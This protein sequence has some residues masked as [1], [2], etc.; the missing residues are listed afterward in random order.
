M[1]QNY[2]RRIG[3]RDIEHW[4]SAGA[5]G[6]HCFHD[7]FLEAANRFGN[8]PA[9]I[10][11]QSSVTFR[12]LARAVLANGRRLAAAAVGPRS[13]VA[14]QVRND[15][16]FL[17]GHLA[18]SSLGAVT[19]TLPAGVTAAEFRE[20]TS[21]GSVDLVIVSPDRRD[22]LAGE[23][24]SGVEV[25][26]F[27]AG[28]LVL[29]LADADT[30]APP[31]W[32]EPDA[33]AVMVPTA[34]TT[35]L[36]KLAIR[37]HNAWLAMGKK[38][39]SSLGGVVPRPGEKVLVLSPLAQGVGY[40]HGFIIPLLIPGV[41]RVIT[42]RFDPVAA[43]D[44]IER[45]RP[46]EIVGVPAQ[47]DMLVEALAHRPRDLSSIRYAQ[48]GGDHM[49]PEK[50]R[51]FEAA[52]G[53]PVLMDYGASD[54][55]A[56]C[57]NRP[58]DPPDVRLTTAGR[59]MPWTDLVILGPEGDPLPVGT[60]GEIALNGPDII[61]GYY[62]DD[63]GRQ[64]QWYRTGD[65][66]HLDEDGNLVVTGRR[67]DLIIRGGLNISPAEIQ[68]VLLRHPSVLS[69]AVVGMTD[70]VLGERIGAFLVVHGDPLQVHASL[71]RY[72]ESSGLNVHKWPERIFYVD[73]LPL[74]PVGK[75]NNSMLRRRAMEENGKSLDQA[76]EGTRVS[77][78][79]RS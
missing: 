79:R 52:F 34:G 50:R 40:I 70:P 2:N 35:S 24:T 5:W 26:S 3:P 75:V 4:R 65:V 66:G 59:A 10:T 58:D 62:P 46:V 27:N 48:T 47:L 15:A 69:A 31:L 53:V 38:K 33:D 57:T 49:A 68:E 9:V 6:D 17:S 20:L 73:E 39:I 13:V 74:T 30:A 55:G 37:T 51:R 7:L 63:A 42:E 18:V 28:G 71:R 77:A 43:L 45:E 1:L 67:T 23:P 64:E 36:P 60:D 11:E 72:L 61:S 12:E 44:L 76:P 29:D 56:G 54:V 14:I 19:M 32:N 8:H 22:A 21:R 78:R 41:C 16:T 25:A